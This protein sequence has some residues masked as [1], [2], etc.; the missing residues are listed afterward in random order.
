MIF[1]YGRIGHRFSLYSCNFSERLK[2]YEEEI[3][4]RG[5]GSN[6]QD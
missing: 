3:S 4:K 6:T 5:G 1:A 2:L